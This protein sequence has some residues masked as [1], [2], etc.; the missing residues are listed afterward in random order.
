MSKEVL[1]MTVSQSIKK[2][3]NSPSWGRHFS[4]FDFQSELGKIE[5]IDEQVET[6][7]I[8]DSSPNFTTEEWE[9]FYEKNICS[10]PLAMVKFAFTKNCIPPHLYEKA[11]YNVYDFLSNRLN[12]NGIGFSKWNVYCDALVG[13]VKTSR[14]SPSDTQKAVDMFLKVDTLWLNRHMV[15]ADNF[16]NDVEL[17]MMMST[18]LE[19]GLLGSCS[20]FAPI[21]LL[22]KH[23]D[24]DKMN[25]SGYTEL[26]GAYLIENKYLEDKVKDEVFDNGCSAIDIANLYS[27]F[28]VLHMEDEFNFTPHILNSLYNSAVDT[29]FCEDIEEY[30][31][32]VGISFLAKVLL[33]R[34][35]YAQT[36]DLFYRLFNDPKYFINSKVTKLLLEETPHTGFLSEIY[37]SGMT[38]LRDYVPSIVKNKNVPDEILIKEAKLVTAALSKAIKKTESNEK[39]ILY[40]VSV[41]KKKFNTINVIFKKKLFDNKQ[42][43]TI[44]NG[45][46]NIFQKKN[47]SYKIV[48]DFM[49]HPETQTFTH[50]FSEDCYSDINFD[51]SFENMK[52]FIDI[53]YICNNSR[54]KR[55]IADCIFYKCYCDAVKNGAAILPLDKNNTF[56]IYSLAQYTEKYLSDKFGF[57]K[58]FL[59][60]KNKSDKNDIHNPEFFC[61]SGLRVFSKNDIYTEKEKSII[62]SL[63]LKFDNLLKV[64]RQ[65]EKGDNIDLLNSSQITKKILELRREMNKSKFSILEQLETYD[66]VKEDLCNLVDRYDCVLKLKKSK[67]EKDISR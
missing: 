21:F 46:N 29:Y 47:L 2:L 37:N 49:K 62:S 67:N 32:N 64:A 66:A 63:E 18:V 9:K 45:L 28:Q 17:D 12:E 22:T 8:L 30:K 19:G 10:Q 6:I 60:E 55:Q 7:K 51:M 26:Y 1:F 53:F 20:S 35:T 56:Q 50:T 16:F 58:C 15:K 42:I 4:S 3:V 14:L 25:M 27:N 59:T 54:L 13:F 61:N 24:A 39:N 52:K 11:F 43:E 65:N 5:N 23:F 57:K 40:L 34:L 44:L 38:G 48:L 33:T 41:Y 36:K 31:R